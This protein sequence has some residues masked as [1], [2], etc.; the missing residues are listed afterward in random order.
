MIGGL[1]QPDTLNVYSMDCSG[2]APLRILRSGPAS[3]T[4]SQLVPQHAVPVAVT[5]CA[6][7]YSVCHHLSTQA[8]VAALHNVHT[9]AQAYGVA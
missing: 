5:A 3:S 6:V 4:C 7:A 9:V 1:S 8:L 2:P